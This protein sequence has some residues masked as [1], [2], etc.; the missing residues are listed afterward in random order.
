MQS[1][2][3]GNAA[4]PHGYKSMKV[5]LVY[6]PVRLEP[7]TIPPGSPVFGAV[8]PQQTPRFV[9]GAG[10]VPV[11]RTAL[12]PVP[13]TRQVSQPVQ[14]ATTPAPPCVVTVGR[15]T[16]RTP[17][18]LPAKLVSVS[19]SPVPQVLRSERQPEAREARDS[20]F[21]PLSTM[22][23]RRLPKASWWLIM[24]LIRGMPWM[25]SEHLGSCESC[26]RDRHFRVPA[27]WKPRM[28]RS[29]FP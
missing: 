27:S 12:T 26:G 14:A 5:T 8:T 21:A 16:P 17:V 11:P 4:P 10:S 28:T 3:H 19:R 15:L 20:V 9:S 2:S 13:G 29:L 18:T 23:P 7:T 24:S 22:Q 1:P 6:P 25:C